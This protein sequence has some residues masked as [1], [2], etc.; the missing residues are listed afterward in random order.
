MKYTITFLFISVCLFAQT[1]QKVDFEAGGFVLAQLPN[2]DGSTIFARTDV[3]G[4]YKKSGSGNWQFI[5]QFAETPAA[6]M[7]QGINI[8]PNNQ[9]EIIAAVGMDYLKDDLGRGLWKSDDEGITWRH[10]LGPNTGHSE[11]NFGGNV[12]RVKLGGPCATW[13]PT[14]PN[15]IICGGLAGISGTSII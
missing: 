7:V 15:R 14:V 1:V 11:V 2:N 8:N 3:G 9:R 10:I 6:L 13:H 12:F 5:G 4:V